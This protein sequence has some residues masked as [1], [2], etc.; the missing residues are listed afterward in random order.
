MWNPPSEKSLRKIPRLYETEDIEV[1]GKLIYLHFF[2]GISDWFV[3]EYDGEDLFFGFA[4]LN[5][6]K[7]LAE[8]GYISFQELKDL[9]VK[10][11]IG[12]HVVMLEVECDEHWDV[13]E[14][15]DVKLIRECQGW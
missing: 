8:W 2:L 10:Q 6:W 4:C 9:K 11:K 12:E 14:A 5:G 7:D 15:K 1:R 3:A 13:R